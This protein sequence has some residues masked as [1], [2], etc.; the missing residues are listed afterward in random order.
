MQLSAR[1][2]T[3][4][5]NSSMHALSD[6]AGKAL[7]WVL[8]RLSLLSICV[9]CASYAMNNSSHVIPGESCGI[10]VHSNLAMKSRMSCR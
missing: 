7:R 9:P 3:R 10:Y 5:L 1:Y 6:R 2:L 8:V 4:F